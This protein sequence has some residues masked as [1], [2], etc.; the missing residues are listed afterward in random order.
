MA[1]GPITLDCACLGPDA[2]S[3]DRIARLQLLARQNGLRL[4]LRNVDPALLELARF[5][6]LAGALGV[7]PERQTE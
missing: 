4:E 6:G 1:I 2:G 5:C 7:E 3:I